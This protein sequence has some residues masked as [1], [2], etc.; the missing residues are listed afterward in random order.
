MFPME[1]QT[2][3]KKIM[4]LIYV[5]TKNEKRQR[6]NPDRKPKPKRSFPD[7]YKKNIVEKFYASSLGKNQF[8]KQNDVYLFIY[9]FT[10]IFILFYFI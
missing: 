9:S 2:E 8:S 10:F 1:I 6:E 7:I 5:E 3:Q 4:K